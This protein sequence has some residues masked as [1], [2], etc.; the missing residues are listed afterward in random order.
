VSDHG[1]APVG[2]KVAL[3]PKRDPGDYW[4]QP[5][6]VK[7]DSSGAFR[8]EDVPNGDYSMS[9]DAEPD[10]PYQGRIAKVKV[11]GGVPVEGL[12]LAVRRYPLVSG[13]VDLS[14]LEAKP[15]FVSLSMDPSENLNEFST[16]K[17]VQ[18]DPKTGK[19]EIQGLRPGSYKGRLF[20]G[21]I[22]RG[23]GQAGT[24]MSTHDL[25]IDEPFVVLEQDMT[26]VVL[27]AAWPQE[28]R[29]R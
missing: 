16:F 25:V 22:V 4:R 10:Q 1:V 26:G 20:C 24:S 7:V 5:R 13:T 8:F 2:L 9:I 14:V 19:F 15:S 18:V 11:V 27:R 6:M 28:Q 21:V 29:I 23:G 12:R 17:S 3:H